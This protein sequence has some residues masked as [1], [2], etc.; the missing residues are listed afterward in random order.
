M[1]PQNTLRLAAIS[2]RL[3]ICSKAASKISGVKRSP[4]VP[5]LPTFTPS[6]LLQTKLKRNLEIEL[7]FQNRFHHN[8]IVSYL[9]F[10]PMRFAHIWWL[11]AEMALRDD[12][13]QQM[14][15]M[16]IVAIMP[17]RPAELFHHHSDTKITYWSSPQKLLTQLSGIDTYFLCSSA[18]GASSVHW[19]LDS[20]LS[21]SITR[22]W[23]IEA[24]NK[25]KDSAPGFGTWDNLPGKRYQLEQLPSNFRALRILVH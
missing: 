14:L 8:T 4:N 10:S 20:V 19:S 9:I 25:S 6:S 18:P 1:H 24:A 5:L 3:P 11:R 22:H 7:Y 12:S 15:V 23:A 17:S 2:L 16:V 21:L 13:G